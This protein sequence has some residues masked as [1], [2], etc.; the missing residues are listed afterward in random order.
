MTSAE[1]A[2]RPGFVRRIYD[3]V[4]RNAEGPR[5]WTFMAL[6]AFAESSFF[7]LPPDILL[8]PMLL[9]DRKRAFRLG[10][11]CTFWS[12]LGGA[13]GY[14]IGHL[15]WD[16]A[17]LWLIGVLNL[18]IATVEGMRATYQEHSYLIAVQGLTPIPYKLVTISAG[19]AGVSF[20]LFMAFSVMAR[21]TRFMAEAALFY[22]FGERARLLLEKYLGPLLI[23]MLILIV[24]GIVA[25]PHLFKH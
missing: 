16:T 4:L 5:A 17:G 14:A 7:P 25:V 3:W 12:V 13:L 24:A 21:G 10:A 9:A 15:F 22:F 23:V 8:V 18:S 19:L 20:P 11:W 6:I 2:A 1:A